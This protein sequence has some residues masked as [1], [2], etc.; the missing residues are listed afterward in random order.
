MK[1]ENDKKTK[2]EKNLFITTIQQNSKDLIL[3]RI[4]SNDKLRNSSSKCT[5]PF[6]IFKKMKENKN[7]SLSTFN[8]SNLILNSLVN[9]TK[10]LKNKS[11][12]A[13]SSKSSVIRFNSNKSIKKY[14]ILE[15]TKAKTND[16]NDK[17]FQMNLFDKLKNIPT[18]KKSIKLINREKKLNAVFGFSCLMSILFQVV[19]TFLYNKKSMEYNNQKKDIFD[20]KNISNY[21]FIQERKISSEVNYMR[22]FNLIFSFLCIVLG[23]KIFINKNK[24]VKQTNKNEKHLYNYN[25]NYR[26]YHINNS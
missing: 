7:K 8:S 12:N 3:E 1:E 2:D 19:D 16:I 6:Q 23:L 5:L 10:L 9:N 17:I 13:S 21:Y 20:L 25:N 15:N 14:H 4:K 11:L 22:I 26:F 24:Y 18:F